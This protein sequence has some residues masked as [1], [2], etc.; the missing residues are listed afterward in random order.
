MFRK[1]SKKRPAQL[2]RRP[3]QDEDD[4]EDDKEDDNVQAK[5]KTAQKKLKIMSSLPLVTGDAI[6]KPTLYDSQQENNEKEQLSALDK[7]HQEAMQEYI[8]QELQKD[9]THS[10]ANVTPQNHSVDRTTT[11]GKLTDKDTLYQEIANELYK[12]RTKEEEELDRGGAVLVGGNTGIAEVVL[13]ATTV[14][15]L[16]TSSVKANPHRVLR[17]DV[18][19]AVPT[20]EGSINTN[21]TTSSTPLVRNMI[22]KQQPNIN[23]NATVLQPKDVSIDK[24]DI[25]D[26]SRLGF[27]AYRGKPSQE[28]KSI[29][30]R[31]R[32]DHSFQQFINRE[33]QRSGI[34]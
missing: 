20:T 6:K 32:D 19:S 30:K 28:R 1:V 11:K 23:A 16:S 5:I 9:K 2:R 31:Q 3:Q 22:I 27:A 24:D 17:K 33:K 34:F 18:S 15:S 21:I 10:K 14:K 13:P 29:P 4:E 7:K 12:G 8:E 26:E 25:D